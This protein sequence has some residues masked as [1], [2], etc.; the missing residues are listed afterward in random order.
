M[1]FKKIKI[2]DWKQFQTIDIDF[3]SNLTVLT[4]ANGSGKTTILNL[5][6]KHF[7]WQID[8]LATPAKDEE[9]GFFKFFT[10]WFKS[11]TKKTTNDIGEITYS[12]NS[13]AP[14]SIPAN[15]NN[16]A[17]YNV[18]IPGMQP[19]KGLNI[20]SHRPVFFYQPVPYIST[21]KRTKEQAYQLAYTS[22]FHK[23]Y[24]ES[25]G[26]KTT[27]YYIKETLLNWAI[28]GNGNEFIQA[29]NELRDN[30]LGFADVLKKILPSSLGFTGVSIRNYEIVLVTD[31]GEFMLDAVSGGVSAIIDLGW[32]IYTYSGLNTDTITVLIDEIE[33]HLHATMQRSILPS[34]IE[35]FP[36]VQFIIST[37]SPLIVGSV[38]NSNVYAFRYDINKKIYDEKLDLINK[39]KNANEILNEVLGVPFT[40]PIWVET[41]L[42]N[43]IDKYANLHVSPTLFKEMREELKTAGLENLM[44]LAMEKTIDRLDDKN[45]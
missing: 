6:A 25:S 9:T 43:I 14:L 17:Q 34:L 29:D 33:N 26:V 37:H 24:T 38:K 35:A 23:M 4:G 40:M 21:Q 27:N 11:E 36:N 5:L 30:F 20:P 42:N 8:E 45:Q 22:I 12:N 39:G 28:G 3:H 32:Q 1:K 13:K 31:T 16:Q 15:N 10:R 44:P 18:S 2:I 19:I 7:G 41:L